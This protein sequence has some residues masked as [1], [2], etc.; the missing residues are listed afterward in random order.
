M[1]QKC[2][3]MVVLNLFVAN[4]TKTFYL[5]EISKKIRLAHTSVKMLLNELKK[6]GLIIEM[7]EK[8][9]TRKYPIF[10]ANINN[11]EFR[12]YKR[13]HNYDLLLESGVV[14]YLGD[15]LMPKC[16]V[17]FG[18]FQ[19]GEDVEDSDVDLYVQCKEELVDL[20]KFE[21]TIGRKIQLHFAP[22]FSEYSLELKNNVL[23]GITLYGFLEGYK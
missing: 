8:K 20:A 11:K 23:N 4:P 10:K 7:V 16:I 13:V 17:V 3:M 21:K 5:M 6:E 12:K 19:K 22:D 9:G 2:S 1:L 18:S 15:H 14:E